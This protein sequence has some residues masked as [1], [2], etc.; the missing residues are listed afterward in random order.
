VL[1]S[2]LLCLR[3]F[4]GCARS[5]TDF[6]EY[7]CLPNR[8]LGSARPSELSS[9]RRISRSRPSGSAKKYSNS[10]ETTTRRIVSRRSHAVQE[11]ALPSRAGVQAKRAWLESRG[12][13]V[14]VLR[15]SCGH[16]CDRETSQTTV[17]VP[18]AARAA[19][20]I[21]LGNALSTPLRQG[22]GLQPRHTRPLHNVIGPKHFRARM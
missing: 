9:T 17:P 2:E 3:F 20:G 6:R 5:S 11:P 19:R 14:R 22:I 15:D 18:R 4:C 21:A 10:N 1:S 13:G 7:K 8:A 16:R 12:Q